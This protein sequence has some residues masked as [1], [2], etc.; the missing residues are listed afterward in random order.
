MTA[1]SAE[2][3]SVGGHRPPLQL[4]TR[5]LLPSNQHN[6]PTRNNRFTVARHAPVAALQFC[7]GPS[8]RGIPEAAC[9][10]EERVG[11]SKL[12][13]C[14]PFPQTELMLWRP[15]EIALPVIKVLQACSWIV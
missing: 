6:H 5:V 11:G 15:C 14:V 7:Q 8:C 12:A 13:S 2:C 3:E 9:F 1:Q 4:L 10:A